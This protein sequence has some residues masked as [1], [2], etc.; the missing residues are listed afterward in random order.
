MKDAAAKKKKAFIDLCKD[1]YEA[2]KL[3]CKKMIMTV[4]ASAMRKEAE[5]GTKDLREKPNHVFK[6]VKLMKRDGK[7][8][9][10]GRCIK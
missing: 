7:D 8:V 5:K 4:V 2:N 10:G 1:G 9:I 6:L 3:L